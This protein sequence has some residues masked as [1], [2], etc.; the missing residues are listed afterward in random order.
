M[1]G[2]SIHRELLFKILLTLNN[3][4]RVKTVTTTMI[5]EKTDPELVLLLTQDDEAAFSELY[6]RYKDK[7]RYFCLSLLKSGEEADDIVQEIFIRI[8]ESRSF[9]NPDLSFSSFLYTLARNRIL[10]HFRDAD[11]DMKVKQIL[12]LKNPTEEN[13]IESD[14]IYAEYKNMLYEAIETLSPQRKKIFNMSR[15][16]N[17]SHKEIAALLG[18]SVNTV[19]EH[20]SESLRSIKS[21]F[22]KHTDISLSLLMFFVV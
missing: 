4:T 14:M 22:L 1:T 7:L 6:V 8:W 10:N 11:I 21:Y 12:A 20:I 18:I 19:Q 9:I 3:T 15:E 2:N 5:R 16:E 17:L 13:V